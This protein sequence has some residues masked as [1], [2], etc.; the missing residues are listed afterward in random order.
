MK[1]KIFTLREIIEQTGLEFENLHNA[2]LGNPVTTIWNSTEA[3]PEHITFMTRPGGTRAKLTITHP[4]LHDKIKGSTKLLFHQSPRYAAAKVAELWWEPVVRYELKGLGGV[5]TY[6]HVHVGRNFTAWPGVVLGADGFGFEWDPVMFTYF[7]FPHLGRVVIGDN[8]EIQSLSNVDRGVL[9]HTRIGDGTKIDSYVHVG[10]NAQIGRNVML[11][12]GVV[13][14][15]SVTI[16]DNVWVGLNS[17]IMQGVTIGKG[18]TIGIGTTVLR[19]VAPGETVVG[20][21]R[22][23]ET[24]DDQRGVIR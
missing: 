10:H 19:D 6:R 7:K 23:I 13:L 2:W 8:V 11:T 9:S 16:K 4:S 22:V 14:G 1:A 3:R 18:A 24:K 20:A 17:T 21:H 12:A 15:G 5:T